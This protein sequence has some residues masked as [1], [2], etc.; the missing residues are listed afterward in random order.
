MDFA[1]R[2]T[3]T[4]DS[5]KIVL[6]AGNPGPYPGVWATVVCEDIR[7]EFGILGTPNEVLLQRARLRQTNKEALGEIATNLLEAGRY[8]L[9]QG[10]R[11]IDMGR[12]PWL[13][14]EKEAK[15]Q[16]IALPAV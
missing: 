6:V 3:L 11:V 8:T 9:L 16:G 15:A 7:Q 12:S 14:R 4:K 1:V 13:V 5:T 10:I 2:P